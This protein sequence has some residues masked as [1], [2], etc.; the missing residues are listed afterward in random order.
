MT[1]LTLRDTSTLQAEVLSR[2][3]AGEHSLRCGVES[4]YVCC[5]SLVLCRRILVTNRLHL[6]RAA[7]RMI[8]GATAIDLKRRT[9]RVFIFCFWY[10]SAFVIT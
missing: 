10:I 1:F 3:R 2:F 7:L 5:E 8:S 4:T 6:G 9:L